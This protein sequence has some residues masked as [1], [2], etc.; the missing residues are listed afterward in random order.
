MK[1][2]G[3]ITIVSMSILSTGLY[4][5]GRLSFTDFGM[6]VTKLGQSAKQLA[7]SIA[8]TIL[9]TLSKHKLLAATTA[10]AGALLT[11]PRVRHKIGDKAL[12]LGIRADAPSIINFGI[13]MGANIEAQ[14]VNQWTP[15]H[16]AAWRGHAEAI[17]ALFE[18]GAN[19]EAQDNFQQ[20][21]L[22]R[23]A[24]YGHTEVIRVL[25]EAGANIEAQD[26]FQQTHLHVASMHG[27]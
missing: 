24:Y 17:R 6:G 2:L 22:H 10:A 13:R 5:F 8:K 18:A 9:S 23:A 20:T 19:I 27:H 11:V 3:L 26:N 4:P 1:R 15:L 16:R 14:D 7:P 25:I 12:L 21:P